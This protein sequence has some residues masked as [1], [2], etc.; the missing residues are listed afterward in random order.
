MAKKG[1]IIHQTREADVAR[2]RTCADATWHARSRA[3][4]TRAHAGA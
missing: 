2:R 1:F 4:A 3:R